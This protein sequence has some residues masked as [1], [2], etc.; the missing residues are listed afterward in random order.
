MKLSFILTANDAPRVCK[1][2]EE[3]FCRKPFSFAA[4]ILGGVLFYLSSKSL[5][6]EFDWGSVV[7]L[8]LGGCSIKW[9]ITHFLMSSILMRKA[10]KHLTHPFKMELFIDDQGFYFDQDRHLKRK[11]V[12]KIW[13]FE[14]DIVISGVRTFWIPNDAFKNPE[15]VNEL[16]EHI[17]RMR[18]LRRVD[19]KKWNGIGK[20]VLERI[21]NR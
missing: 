11:S 19:I 12:T 8:V 20:I 6:K 3:G 21:G 2:M 5:T 18:D 15:D 13:F 9:G 14:K 1:Q 17:K 16:A 4:F 7:G 10:K